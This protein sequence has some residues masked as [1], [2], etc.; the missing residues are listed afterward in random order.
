MIQA[1]QDTNMGMIRG[2]PLALGIELLDDSGIMAVLV[3]PQFEAGREHVGKKGVVR[4][5]AVH[6]QVIQNIAWKH[7][8]H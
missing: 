3:K 1:I 4:D 7:T 5:P 2:D 8:P 6:R